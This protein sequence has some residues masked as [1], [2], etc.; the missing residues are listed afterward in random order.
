MSNAYLN[1]NKLNL[2]LSIQKAEV[3]IELNFNFLAKIKTIFILYNIKKN[4]A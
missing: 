4:I 2:S 3:S 1:S